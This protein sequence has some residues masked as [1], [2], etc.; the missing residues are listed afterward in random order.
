MADADALTADV[1]TEIEA[2]QF[3]I[4]DVGSDWVPTLVVLV[5][6]LGFPFVFIL[7]WHFDV[8]A[9]GVRRTSPAGLLSRG[10]S[11]LLFSIM[12]AAMVGL[13]YG[14]YSAYSGVFDAQPQ[15]VV[16]DERSFTA[17]ENSIAVLPFADLSQTGDQAYL[18]D[19]VSE[20]ILNLLAQVDGLNVA[21]RT[22]SFAF[23]DRNEDI[24]EIGRLLNV[25]T[26]LEG[27]VRTSG[28]RIRL[29]AQL[30]NVEDGFHIWSKYYDSE[31][32]DIFAIQD[33]VASNIA[34]A[35]VDSFEGLQTRS[36][37][38]T[39]SLAASQAYR[40]G[41]LHW[42]RRTPE[43]LQRAIALFATALEYDAEFAPAYAALA[44]SYLLLSQYGNITTVKA[45][46]V[47]RHLKNRIE[48]VRNYGDIP[49]VGAG[50]DR[51]GAGDRSDIRR[52]LRGAGPGA[53]ADR[54]DGRGRIGF[55]PI[56]RP[57]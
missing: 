19:G 52:G 9:E 53:L 55:S 57:E 17:P 3:T 37:S 38:Q 5:A 12:L 23:R 46:L 30:I 11:A 10:Q 56:H 28:D 43:E 2:V 1:D 7:A 14:F 36:E 49:P 27:S 34:T 8:G 39:D 13:G 4:T 20:E 45:T 47:H 24:R 41:R 33:E 21:A 51:E 32:T 40:T 25:R 42:W 44:D 22:S 26:V 54:P 31:M 50:H 29:T 48:V 6:I 15:A 16:Q 18:A 35:L